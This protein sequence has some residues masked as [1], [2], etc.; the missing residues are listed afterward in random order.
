[1]VYQTEDTEITS[2]GGVYKLVIHGCTTDMT[3]TIKCVAGNKMGEAT[4]EGTVYE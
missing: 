3:G 1:M 4:K 2:E